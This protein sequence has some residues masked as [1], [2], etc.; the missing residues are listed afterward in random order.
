SLQAHDNRDISDLFC[1]FRILNGFNDSICYPVATYD[2]AKNVNQDR[3]YIFVLK[4]NSKA[5]FY[6][7]NVSTAANIEEVG[8]VTAG[9]F[10]NIH[11]SH[12]QAG[13]IDHTAHITI[14][15]DIVESIF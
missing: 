2:A 13:S 4:N 10:N 1:N 6:G 5:I 11:C 9:K 15:L 3:L 8:R 12:C 7:F 14:E